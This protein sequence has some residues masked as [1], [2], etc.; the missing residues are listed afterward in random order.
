MSSASSS[1]G[2][3]AGSDFLHPVER[4]A[5]LEPG[6]LLLVAGVAQLDALGLAVFVLDLTVE[7][8][9]QEVIITFLFFN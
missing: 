3:L 5:R 9:E 7:R 8:L 1:A 6:D 4:G 2:S